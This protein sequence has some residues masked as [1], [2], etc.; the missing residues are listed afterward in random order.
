[1]KR[2]LFALITLLAL[3]VQG[4]NPSFRDLTNVSTVMGGSLVNF[5]T[6]GQTNLSANAIGSWGI[7][8]LQRARGQFIKIAAGYTNSALHYNISLIGDSY[9]QNRL[10]WSGDFRHL[11]K[12]LLGDGGSGWCSWSAVR[13]AN[14]AATMNQSAEMWDLSAWTRTGSW[15]D[16]TAAISTNT[17]ASSPD[18]HSVI[19]TNFQDRVSVVVG[20]AYDE[21]WLYLRQQPNGT[22][23]QV[24]YENPGV[25]TNTFSSTT[26]GS[27]GSLGVQNHQRAK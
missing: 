8:N 4:A 24:I 22:A 2:L 23:F 1:M 18:L 5:D 13:P 12:Y 3:T 17:T 11:L 10:R 27:R 26:S 25:A 7:W 9:T 6:H 19:A 15:Y 16:N 21:A 14:V 20:R